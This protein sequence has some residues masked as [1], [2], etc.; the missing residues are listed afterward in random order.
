MFNG[1]KSTI[2]KELALNLGFKEL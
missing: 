1:Q 2:S